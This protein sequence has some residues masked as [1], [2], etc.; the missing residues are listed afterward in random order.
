[1]QQ[2]QQQWLWLLVLRLLASC[3]SGSCLFSAICACNNLKWR[4]Q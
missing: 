1:M 3:G 4:A 2:Q